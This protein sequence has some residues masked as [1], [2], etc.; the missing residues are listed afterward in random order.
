MEKE[1]RNNKPLIIGIDDAGRGPVIG[2]MCLAG[3]L[4]PREIEEE[5]RRAGI[6]DSKLLTAK[7][8]EELAEIIKQTAIDYHFEILTPA[9]IDTGMGTGVNL[10]EVEAMAAA[11]IINNLAGKL[12]EEQK[13]N[14]VIVLDCPSNNPNAWLITLG[15]YIKSEN[16]KIN[17]RAEHKAD[18]HYPSVSAASIIAKT[19]RDSEI[20]K[21]KKELGI[22]FG[23]GYPADPF[24]K[25]AL[26][27]H[28]EILLKHRMIRES[29]ATYQNL[30][31]KSEES[32]KG[33]QTKLFEGDE[34]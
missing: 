13:K 16:K 28:K 19:T 23:S 33:R 24:T 26:A 34:R 5:F 27:E 29:W 32:K 10:N 25:K 21:I 18:F 20:E 9:E 31:K 14:L 3:V 17:M 6:K 30:E 11:A 12:N 8:R 15:K 4:I 7:K 1:G 2:P 22:D